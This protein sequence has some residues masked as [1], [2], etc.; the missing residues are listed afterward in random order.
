MEAEQA[1]I[2]QR[3]ADGSIYRDAPEE[4]KRLNERAAAL[5]EELMAAM[6]RWE[7]LETKAAEAAS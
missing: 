3:L 6:E 4:A 7:E 1:T 5:D 2:G